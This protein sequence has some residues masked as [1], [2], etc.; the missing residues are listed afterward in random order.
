[1]S[2][3]DRTSVLKSSVIVSVATMSSRVL[4]L[5]RDIVFASLFGAGGAHDAFFVAFKVPNFLRRLFAEGA[6]N[7]AF[8][9]V[10]S[11]YKHAEGDDS[12]RRLVSAVQVYLGAIVGAVTVLAMIFSPLVAWLFASG[13]H[14]DGAKLALVAGFLRLTFP[15]LW[16]ISMTAL[17]SSVLNSYQNFA[18]PALTPIILN[19]SLIGAA[20]LL[21]PRFEVAQTGLA[22]GVLLAGLLQWLFLWPALLKT[23]V[24]SPFSFST[25]HPGVKK[26]LVLMLPGLFGVSVSQINL[27]LDTILATWLK[28]GSVGWLYYSDRLTELP[29]GVIGVAIGTVLLPRL[30][31]L[32]AESDHSVFER[33]LAWAIRMVLMVGLPAMAAL[34]ILSNQLLT[35][36]FDNGEFGSTDVLMSAKSLA[37]YA[38]GLPAFMLI[39]IL[40]PAFFARQDTRTPVKTGVQAMMW[41]MV[42][43]LLLIVPLQHVGLALATSMSAWINAG[44]LAWHL[45][46]ERH[47]PG[48]ALLGKS[49]IQVL[50]ATIVMALV[51]MFMVQLSAF[52]MPVDL[53]GRVLVVFGLVLAGLF[54]YGLALFVSGVR[55]VDIKHP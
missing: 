37:A 29:L 33:T 6:F 48:Q 16:F 17:G 54:S 46:Q 34:L 43:N 11:E 42:F 21:S 35:L 7:Q 45:R 3:K 32:H 52:T 44:L 41:N 38:L 51:L 23:G 31:S 22:L 19:L 40:A 39:K 12:V 30:S 55:L 4:G 24:W 36:L 14:D 5:V 18:I 47:L 2:K 50:V 20:F 15:Y 9:P 28:D 10:L 27:L 13:F 1:M 53:F 26:I 8:V 25:V 49:I